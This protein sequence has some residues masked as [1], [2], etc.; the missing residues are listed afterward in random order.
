[1]LVLALTL[2]VMHGGAGG[3]ANEWGDVGATVTV[4]RVSASVSMVLL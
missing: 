4:L 3:H 2:D 1:M